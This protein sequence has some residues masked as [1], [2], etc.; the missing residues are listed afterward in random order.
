[1]SYFT[2]KLEELNDKKRGHMSGL[3]FISK[4]WRKP[5]FNIYCVYYK[6]KRYA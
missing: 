2:K 6:G 4:I 5:K 1:M 3:F